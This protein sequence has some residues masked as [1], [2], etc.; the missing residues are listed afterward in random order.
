MVS[1]VVFRREPG[2]VLINVYLK[3][4]VGVAKH[5]D[6]ALRIAFLEEQAQPATYVMRVRDEPPHTEAF[7]DKTSNIVPF[8]FLSCSFP[9]VLHFC[10][11][12]PVQVGG[13][14]GVHAGGDGPTD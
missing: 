10:A 12:V 13:G 8:R 14:D 5:A 3:E 6:K 2:V 4:P 9:P 11:R 7:Q 1:R